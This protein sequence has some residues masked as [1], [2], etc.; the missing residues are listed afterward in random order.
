MGWHK[1]Q[2]RLALRILTDRAVTKLGVW[3]GWNRVTLEDFGKMHET[4]FIGRNMQSAHRDSGPYTDLSG[5][6][7]AHMQSKSDKY[8]INFCSKNVEH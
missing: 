1:D 3:F 4:M 7:L 6:F 2:D 5:I 8:M